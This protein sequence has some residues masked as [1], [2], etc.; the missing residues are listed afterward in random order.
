MGITPNFAWCNRNNLMTELK[1]AFSFCGS[2]ASSNLHVPLGTIVSR[3]FVN[4]GKLTLPQG[5]SSISSQRIKQFCGCTI[6]PNKSSIRERLMAL[7]FQPKTRLLY[8]IYAY[9]G[10]LVV[11]PNNKLGTKL[12]GGFKIA[13]G[14]DVD[15]LTG[16]IVSPMLG[17]LSSAQKTPVQP[18]YKMENLFINHTNGSKKK[19][20]GAKQLAT[21]YQL[22][23]S[24]EAIANL[25]QV[26][27]IY[28]KGDQALRLERQ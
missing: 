12:V 22:A 26:S 8:I 7:S 24:E 20:A 28:R 19:E 3:Q 2:Q 16:N 18:V 5:V 27:A 17:S 21:D 14:L 1:L 4:S 6:D 25:A 11:G 13:R 23:R 15:L 9:L 10:L